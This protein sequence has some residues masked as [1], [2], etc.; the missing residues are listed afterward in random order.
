MTESRTKF[1]KR[2]VMQDVLSFFTKP[3][4]YKMQLLSRHFYE[5]TVPKVIFQCKFPRTKL[6]SISE[7][8]LE[9]ILG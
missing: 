8:E 6:K 2:S 1:Y 9:I 3:E 7:E 4:L 5:D